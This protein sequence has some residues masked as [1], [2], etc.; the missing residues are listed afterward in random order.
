M[1]P[2]NDKTQRFKCI[3]KYLCLFK[4]IYPRINIAPII[5]QVVL[6]TCLK[7]TSKFRQTHNLALNIGHREFQKALLYLFQMAKIPPYPLRCSSEIGSFYLT[8]K[9][10]NGV[11][12]KSNAS[13]ER[14]TE[15][16]YIGSSKPVFI[17]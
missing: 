9:L 8:R 14:G 15:C 3:F 2:S 13:M 17:F 5:D 6:F 12:I 7:R 4:N 16:E 1:P 10:K 11:R